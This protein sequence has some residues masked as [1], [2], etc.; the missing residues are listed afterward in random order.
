MTSVSS[1]RLEDAILASKATLD[2]WAAQQKAIA[3]RMTA[4]A[5]EQFA[6]FEK[7]MEASHN[8]LL[9]LQ[10]QRGLRTDDETN[11]AIEKFKSEIEVRMSEN[12]ELEA[13]LVEKKSDIESK[14]NLA[15]IRIPLTQI[16]DLVEERAKREAAAKQLSEEKETIE[17]ASK[18]TLDDL[19]RGLMCFKSLGL[20]MEKTD[21]NCISLRF[22]QIDPDEPAK[23]FSIDIMLGNEWDVI[24]CPLLPV[25]THEEVIAPLNDKNDISLFVR[26][27]RK[28]F[29]NQLQQ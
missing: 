7:R 21:N 12:E 16:S 6:E 28:A 19:T 15:M 27:V 17:L 18:A 9:A 8:R 5:A 26:T 22:S 20:D 24:S 4:E 11:P 29:L 2:R 3:D 10:L 13:I 14:E 25:E 23:V 1:Q